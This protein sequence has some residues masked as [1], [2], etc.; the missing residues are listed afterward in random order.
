MKWYNSNF[1]RDTDI[2]NEFEIR[3]DNL[4][5]ML[6]R[7][8]CL[9]DDK[10]EKFI[11]LYEDEAVTKD[12]KKKFEVFFKKNKWSEN[13]V[14]VY[15]SNNNLIEKNFYPFDNFFMEC[16]SLLN[17]N[18]FSETDYENKKSKR[19]NCLNNSANKHRDYIY[20]GLQDKNLL[21]F[22][23]VSYI[24][25]G[26]RLPNYLEEKKT[27][28]QWRWD[29]LNYK[30]TSNTYFNIVTE[31]HHDIEHDFDSKFITEKTCKAIISQPFIFVGNVNNLRYVK[32]KGFET[33][34]EIFDESYD[35]I[36]NPKERLDFVLN[37]IE[38]VCNM[39]EKK[40]KDLYQ[41]VIWKIKHN[42]KVMSEF[43]DDLNAKKYI[44]RRGYWGGII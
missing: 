20:K 14:I 1:V 3:V 13:D 6:D 11:I 22:G 27:F 10:L 37:E 38:R 40:L 29:T 8:R 7:K 39:E 21:S 24:D 15:H 33:Y 5:P 30:I 23:Y 42:M 4:V 43:Q 2:P 25:K 31:T 36:N 34:S 19:Y 18:Y 41:S 9:W 17:N 44:S 32:E 35:T 26:I 16:K 12:L 28:S